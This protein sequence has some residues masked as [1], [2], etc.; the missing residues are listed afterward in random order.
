MKIDIDA[1]VKAM[2]LVS[3]V[4]AIVKAIYD[5]AKPL[6]DGADQDTLKAAYDAA[7]AGAQRD[8]TEFQKEMKG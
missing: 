3:P 1:V 7:W 5:Q 2:S 4:P 6:F 8:H